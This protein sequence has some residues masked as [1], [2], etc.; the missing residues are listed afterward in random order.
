[1]PMYETRYRLPSGRMVP[2]QCYA[3]G[4][5]HLDETMRSRGLGEISTYDENSSFIEK[6]KM[7]STLIRCGEIAAAQHALTWVSMIAV[8][9]GMVD[10][11]ELLHDDG[12]IHELAHLAHT[13]E[14]RSR[15]SAYRDALAA[16]YEPDRYEAERLADKIETFERTVPGVHPSWAQDEKLSQGSPGEAR[17]A[18]AFELQVM[19]GQQ[20]VFMRRDGVMVTFD[21]V[22]PS[23]SVA[24]AIDKLA[25]LAKRRGMKTKAA[26][27]PAMTANDPEHET[28][29]KAIAERMR[30]RD[31][32]IFEAIS[33]QLL[34]QQLAE[35]ALAQQYLNATRLAEVM[36]IPLAPVIERD[37]ARGTVY[38]RRLASRTAPNPAKTERAA[39]AQL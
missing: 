38:L 2:T 15:S 6:P 19:L 18:D 26:E 25:G 33:R 13:R 20:T 32:S 34:Q 27:A 37:L 36:R 16:R 23:T 29:G 4:P 11:W 39:P 21:E 17:A 14:F 8:R 31:Y 28:S 35:R 7:P 30:S 12:L 24:A 9:A 5:A 10:G 22:T 1:M 3:R